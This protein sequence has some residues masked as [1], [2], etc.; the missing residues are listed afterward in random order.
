MTRTRHIVVVGHGMV[1]ARFAEEVAARDPRGE[2]VRLTLVGAEPEGPYN[3]VLL[4]EAVNGQLRPEELA[5]PEV[6]A[7]NVTARSGVAATALDR[8]ARRVHLDDGG[9]LDYDELVLATGADP[10]FPP[11]RGLT[12]AGG[13]PADG[14]TALRDMADCRRVRELS[15]AGSPLVVL[16]GGV[17]GLEAARG[18]NEAGARVA[19]VEGAPWLMRR[20]LGR[21]AAGILAER[22][23]S[24]GVQV[25]TWRVAERWVPGRGLELDDGRTLA[26]DGVVVTAGV[27]ARTGLAADSGLAVDHGVPVGDTLATADP[28]VHAI[29]DCAQHPGGGAGLVAPGWEMARVLADLLTG[30]DPGARYTGSRDITR[31]KAAGVDLTALGAAEPGEDAETVTVS[32]PGGGRYAALSVRHGRVA[33]AVLLGFPEAA[34]TIGS[35]YTDDA[36]VPEDRLALLV[37]GDRSEAD[38]G[39]DS[40]GGDATVCHCNAVTRGQLESA[41]LEG[42][43]TRCDLAERT[44]ATTGCGSCTRDVDAFVS[45]MSDRDTTPVP[46]AT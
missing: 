8:T 40:G 19:L 25:H 36:P 30:S 1:G 12:D 38:T 9:E 28:R 33:G 5:L 22:F 4:S 27:R 45:A 6:A 10:V 7:P 32:D 29:G 21:E 35:L 24:L 3:R 15:R 44:R 17:L 16:G 13:R 20:Q 42:A 39:T 14:V 41:W 34:A 37:G 31:L 18:L 2:R 43:R 11:V 46:A 26:A 23:R